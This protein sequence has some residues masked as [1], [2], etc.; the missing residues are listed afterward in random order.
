MA[1]SVTNRVAAILKRLGRKVRREL[2]E[3]R[4]PTSAERAFISANKAFWSR[5]F[6]ERSSL[7]GYVLVEP[8]FHP[9][10]LLENANIAAMAAIERDLAPL[11][12][13]PNPLARPLRKTMSSYPRARIDY[14]FDFKSDVLRL[15]RSL[16]AAYRVYR[17]LETPDDILE[18]ASDGITY[19]DLVYDT[20]L[21]QGYATVDKIDGRALRE[22]WRF[23]YYRSKTLDLLRRYKITTG[24]FSGRL[25][26]VGGTIY[27]YLAQRHIEI[28]HRSG[29]RI[30]AVAKY[31]DLAD[32]KGSEFRPE[33]KYV[34]QM[35]RA[36][37]VVLP[38]ADEYMRRRLSYEIDPTA[39][40]HAFDTTRRTFTS[41]EEFC[42]TYGLDPSRPL[43]FVLLHAFNDHPHMLG[44]ILFRDYFKWFETTL[45]VAST[46]DT[47]NWV[48]KEHPAAE[49]Y[50]TRDFDSAAL[51]RRLQGRS[52]R[53]L[54]SK[55][56]FN[57]KSLPQI[58]H[59]IVTC[60]G[61][62][63]LEYSAL[64]VPCLLAGSAPYSGFGFTVE[65]RSIDEYV[66]ALRR[67]DRLQP[68]TA[69]QTTMAKLIAYFYLHI[70]LSPVDPFFRYYDYEEIVRETFE[71]A[72]KDA[73]DILARGDPALNEHVDRV[74]RFL[75]QPDFTQYVDLEMF[76]FL[77]GALDGPPLAR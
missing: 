41:R 74:R 46:V 17:T 14:V 22:L 44:P 50:E 59:A 3:L 24:A 27:R 23:F 35:I 52:V 16:W 69:E 6:P 43:V 63:G 20:V 39:T 18:L 7:K 55:A 37:D 64:G 2:S 65:P 8:V 34:D 71:R 47:V 45:D 62:A 28:V 58:A 73:A 72:W 11:F 25:S 60:T 12:L 77:K 38:A 30:F 31:S 19:G 54:D 75:R 48:F 29:P 51:Q 66:D 53:Y 49:F 21:Q 1:A 36:R 32:A 9:L 70:T 15:I 4:P 56:D 33:Q 13:L 26:V 40:A 57:A 61:T 42:S 5:Q 76:P 68:P 67:I 10:M